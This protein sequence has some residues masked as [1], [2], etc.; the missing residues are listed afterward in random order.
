MATEPI[1][2]N[3]DIKAKDMAAAKSKTRDEAQI[4][5]LIEARV[6]ARLTAHG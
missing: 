4:R 5:A 6:T 1:T 2:G 3:M